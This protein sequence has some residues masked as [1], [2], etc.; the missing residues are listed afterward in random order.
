MYPSVKNVTPGDNYVLYVEFE[1]GES[2]LLDMKP[3]LDFGTFKRLK[4]QETFKQVRVKFDT[5][6]WNC[7]LDLDPEYVYEKAVRKEPV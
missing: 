4:D 5:I 7:G 1:N 6:E 2:G 3:A